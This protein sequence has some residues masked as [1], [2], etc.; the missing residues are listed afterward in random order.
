MG[1][2]SDLP[3]PSP[4]CLM[5]TSTAGRKQ[6]WFS[7]SEMSWTISSV[8]LMLFSGLLAQLKME[9]KLIG[10][11]MCAK[12]W[13]MPT[14]VKSHWRCVQRAEHRLSEA[15]REMEGGVRAVPLQLLELFLAAVRWNWWRCHTSNLNMWQ[16]NIVTDIW[17]QNGKGNSFT[18]GTFVLLH[19]PLIS[20]ELFAYGRLHFWL[21]ISLL[22]SL[23]PDF[24]NTK[25]IAGVFH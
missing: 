14:K 19:S 7:L 8:Y 9:M 15:A 17:L 4:E 2:F 16:L 18:L 3:N 12:H 21:F 20:L 5:C 24:L 25:W 1:E 13:P 11:F 6:R 23:H 22:P 10:F